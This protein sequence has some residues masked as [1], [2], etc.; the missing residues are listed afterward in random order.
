MRFVRTLIASGLL[1]LCACQAN[2][3]DK[4]T[5]QLRDAKARVAAAIS[6]STA[7]TESDLEEAWSD[8]GP[9]EVWIRN[10]T[11]PTLL[12]VLPDPDKATGAAVLVV[13]GG[14]FQ[15]VSITN[16]GY[17]IADWLAERGVAAFVLKYRVMKTPATDEG[18]EK[19]LQ[20]MFAPQPGDEP[21][22]SQL[23]IPAAVE[24]AK[25]ALELIYQR[26]EEWG[27]DT[28][29]LGMIGFSAGAVTTM[30]VI[31][32]D[33][34]TPDFAGYIYGPMIGVDVPDT[35]PPLFI[36]LAAD[37]PLFAN[38]GFGLLESWRAAEKPVEFH[39]Y[40]NGGHGFGS[41]KL[42]KTSDAWFDQFVAWMGARGILGN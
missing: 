28:D 11:Q 12:P 42:G 18:F 17:P 25:A 13:P 40:E 1:F 33:G 6:L 27:V 5:D 23:G 2:G 4:I 37:D 20:R 22:R 14:G 9:S 36:G 30:G 15:F 19:H 8:M 29:R 35:A 26:S 16:E 31:T 32:S 24:D 21:I 34:P 39:Y 38:Q 10:V 3:E 7:D 41:K